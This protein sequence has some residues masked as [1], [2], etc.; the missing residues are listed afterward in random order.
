MGGGN[1]G[2]G[3]GRKLRN[4]KR[5]RFALLCGRIQLIRLSLLLYIRTYGTSGSPYPCISRLPTPTLFSS[6]KIHDN[7]LKRYLFLNVCV[8]VLIWLILFLVLFSCWVSFFSLSNKNRTDW[9][10]YIWL[11][12][13]GTSTSWR[14]CWNVAPP[15]IQPPRKATLLYTSLHSVNRYFSTPPA[16]LFFCSQEEVTSGTLLV[17]STHPL[18]FQLSTRESENDSA[19]KEIFLVCLFVC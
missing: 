11:P 8:C 1:A 16:P 14:S 5:N 7:E 12:R 10:P 9:M 2:C 4:P 18:N 17:P 13:K 6:F 19:K 15:S 3:Y